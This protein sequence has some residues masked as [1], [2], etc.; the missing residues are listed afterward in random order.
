MYFSDEYDYTERRTITVEAHIGRDSGH[1]VGL[2]IFD[3][4]LK[5]ETRA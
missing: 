1:I 2:N 3:E 4:T 5:K